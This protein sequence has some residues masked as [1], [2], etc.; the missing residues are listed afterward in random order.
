MDK[1]L[2]AG[3]L[4]NAIFHYGFINQEVG[5]LA[6]R[7][8]FESEVPSF[9]MDYMDGIDARLDN[10]LIRRGFDGLNRWSRCGG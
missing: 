5:A 10:A 6:G 4:R 3:R 7:Y 9:L 1:D 8:S 2:H